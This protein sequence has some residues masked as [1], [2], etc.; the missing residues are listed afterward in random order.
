LKRALFL[1]ASFASLAS[2]GL[3]APSVAFAQD[4][5]PGP[6]FDAPLPPEEPTPPPPEAYGMTPDPLIDVRNRRSWSEGATR[7]FLATTLDV[8]WVYLR[9]RASLGYG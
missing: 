9:P 7:T 8:G 3:L 6:G 5:S 1:L 4:V 2:L